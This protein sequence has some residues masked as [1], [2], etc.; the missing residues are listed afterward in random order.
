LGPSGA[1]NWLRLVRDGKVAGMK[2]KFSHL[3]KVQLDPPRH[4][5][6]AS[7]VSPDEC[8]GAAWACTVPL[9]VN[10]RITV[11]GGFDADEVATPRIAGREAGR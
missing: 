6:P 7:S 10:A 8:T 4:R 3:T 2:H 9:P 5:S 11:P 1:T